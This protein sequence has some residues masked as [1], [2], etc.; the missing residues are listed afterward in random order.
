MKTYP[1]L[2]SQ[3]GVFYDCLKFPNVMQYNCPNITQLT[4]DLDLDRIERALQT[5]FSKRKEL[6]IRFLMDDQGEPRQY[7][8]EEKRLNIVRREMAEDDFQK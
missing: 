6:S 1:L 3:L 8:D 5:I 7:V 4:D 2:Q